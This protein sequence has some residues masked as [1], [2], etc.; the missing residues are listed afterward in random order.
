MAYKMKYK[1]YISKVKSSMKS[2]GGW[3]DTSEGTYRQKRKE[4]ERQLEMN[5]LDTE[6]A[7]QD[8]S[9]DEKRKALAE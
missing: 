5:T 4:K 7:H 1:G 6:M 8:L 3:Q 2:W 9:V